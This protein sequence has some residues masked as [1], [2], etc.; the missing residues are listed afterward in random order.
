MRTLTDLINL[1]LSCGMDTFY[2][3]SRFVGSVENS[4]W[5]IK[6]AGSKHG[7]R[8][9]SPVGISILIYVNKKQNSRLWNWPRGWNCPLGS[10]FFMSFLEFYCIASLVLVFYRMSAS[11]NLIL[12]IRNYSYDISLLLAVGD[13][14]SW[15]W[16][17]LQS[18]HRLGQWS[19]IS[20]SSWRHWKRP[21]L[22]WRGGWE[23]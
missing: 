8:P 22:S 17:W 18:R 15:G 7:L 4:W 3:I 19:T 10:L 20:L 23:P 5:L 11:L 2:E 16:P 13:P 1:I 12:C 6:R 9:D 14:P 21:R